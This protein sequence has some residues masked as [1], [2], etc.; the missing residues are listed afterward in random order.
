MATASLAGKSGNLSGPDSVSEI[1]EWTCTVVGDPLDATSFA[2]DGWREFIFGLESGTGSFTAV[3]DENI[4]VEGPVSLTLK[5]GGEGAPQ[6]SGS[7]LVHNCETSVPHDGIV[8]YRADFN[9]TGS[10]T[11][12][13]VEA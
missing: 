6:I 8:E 9:F 7:A 1:R 2:S 4:S 5:A 11:V 3:G 12:D 10:V 13:D